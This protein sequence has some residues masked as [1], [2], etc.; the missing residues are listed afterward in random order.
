MPRLSAL[1][2]RPPRPPRAAQ[3]PT[4]RQ[5]HDCR[6]EDEFAWL[7]AQNWQEVI[8]DPSRLAPE[9]ARYLL[10]ENRY[11]A[12]R[13]RPL[14]GL[15]KRLRAEMRGRLVETD[16]E[17]PRKHGGFL[18]YERF[19]K[20][21]QHPII[22]R[23]PVT[24]G[25]EQVL[26]DGAF[27]ARGQDFFE[28]GETRI[29]PAHDLLAWSADRTGSES[30]S[31][32]IRD[33]ASGEDR[34]RL[35]RCS[36][37]L[38]WG[39]SGTFFYYVAL[40]ANQRPHRVLRHHLGQDQTQDEE[41]FR[42]DGTGWFL[43]VQGSQD[44]RFGFIAVHDHETSEVHRLD[45]DDPTARPVRIF[46]REPGIEYEV[47][48][49]QGRLI[50]RS[51]ADGAH[52][53]RLLAVPL[54]AQKLGDAE[55]LV[56]EPEG[57]ILLSFAVLKNW[58]IWTEL[59]EKGP[60]VH[61]R[62]WDGRRAAS[63]LPRA[64]VGDVSATV[65]PDYESDVLRLSFSAPNDPEIILDHDLSS[66]AEIIVKEQ[67][68]PSGHDRA[69]YDVARLFAP[70]PDGQTVP[71]TL[72]RRAG[73]AADGKGAAL[74][75]GYGAY[76]APMSA[77]FETERLSLVDR[78]C[79]FAIAHVRGGLEKGFDWY[80][81]GKREKKRNTFT[82]FIAVADF[83][84]AQGYAAPGRIVAEGASAGGMLMGAVA[85]MAGEKFAGI[86]AEV[87]FVDC[88]NTILDETLPLTPAEWVEWG[89][90]IRDPAVLK[91]MLAYSP[92]DNIEA[93]SYPPM[94]VI[95][96]LTDPRVTY[97]EPA[98]F[99]ARLRARMTGGGPILLHTEMGAGH[100]G[101]PGRF[102]RLNDIAR[103]YAFAI[104]VLDLPEEPLG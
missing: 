70:A 61:V 12:E 46:A 88:V 94:L 63:F 44:E 50:I 90:P 73:Q 2:H 45:L 56:P 77:D 57:R 39:K 83:L 43:N 103:L 100:G 58:L 74:L 9:I 4:S 26:L 85:N 64:E 82:D 53:F 79:V 38:V 60:A 48:H 71:V 30:F 96:G 89:D 72:L 59:G 49:H 69:R 66:G 27:E 10:A 33:L 92:Y 98:K 17:P 21:A 1:L 41:I 97:W 42:E 86:I 91:T 6:L 55:I 104:A 47:E 52:N 18:Y 87:P 80:R 101:A 23:K 16:S 54:E 37:D 22:C 78:G 20:G 68:V 51:N 19:R 24:G 65:G 93:K 31:L 95:G 28:L 13:L 7:R 5:V 15:R 84:V 67:K 75:Y 3:R 102:E 62:G 40:D 99:V 8:A 32:A 76:G 35:E 14:Q 36:G 81:D 29:A 11:A 34:D 25:R